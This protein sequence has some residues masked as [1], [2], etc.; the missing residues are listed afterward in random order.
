[1]IR[2]FTRKQDITLVVILN[3][4]NSPKARLVNLYEMTTRV[5]SSMYVYGERR[6]AGKFV[7]YARFGATLRFWSALTKQS[8]TA[9]PCIIGKPHKLFQTSF[10]IP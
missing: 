8:L 3:L 7:I 4:S 5:I 2:G 6:K 10:L 1:M 9:T